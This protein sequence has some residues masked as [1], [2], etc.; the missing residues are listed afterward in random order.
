MK[1]RSWVSRLL[2]S[3]G[4]R[5]LDR[6]LDEEIAAHLEAIEQDA[7]AAGLSA[8]AARRAA[9]R[10]FG[11]IERMKEEHRDMR[12]SRHLESVLQDL[13]FSFRSIHRSAGHSALIAATLALGVAGSSAILS[14][15][16]RLFVRPLPFPEAQRL[17]H[18]DE[19][20][21]DGQESIRVAY[22][23]FLEWQ[24]SAQSFESM[25]VW[26]EEGYNLTAGEA[27]E[28]IEG[29]RVSPGLLNVLGM[30]PALGRTFTAA[31]DQENGPNVVLLSH[32]L[33]QR[34]FD[35]RLDVLG[36]EIELDGV[37]HE[38]VGVLPPEAAYPDHCD[39]W[40]PLQ[41]DPEYGVGWFLIGIARLRDGSSLDAAR[42]ELTRLH[43]SLTE[44]RGANFVTTPV[45]TDFRSHYLGD[46][47][48][49]ASLLLAGVG[50]ALLIAAGNAAGL[51]LIGGL[52]RRNE[53]LTRL[54]LG[55]SRARIVRQ[56]TTES[57]LVALTGAAL[58]ALLG[59]QALAAL[60]RFR[61]AEL[62]AWL[63]FDLDGRFLFTAVVVSLF[64]GLIAGSAAALGATR[65]G[66]S[67]GMARGSASK[68]DR[69]NLDALVV[70]QAGL[71]LALLMTV[72]LLVQALDT[73][74]AVDPGF[75]SE[76]VLTFTM[77]LPGWLYPQPRQRAEFFQELVERLEAL[78][79]VSAAGAISLA[80]LENYSA[81]NFVVEGAGARDSKEPEPPVLTQ[82]AVP[83]YFEA[84]GI[85]LIAGRWFDERE[86]QFDAAPVVIVN[87]TFVR[88]HFPDSS[89]LG[90]RVRYSYR[91]DEWMTVVGVAAD[92]RHFGLEREPPLG[93]YIPLS[94]GQSY[95]AMTMTLK[96]R[97][98]PL[99]LMPDIQRIASEMDPTVPV[100]GVMSLTERLDRTLFMRRAYSW[101]T[102]AFALLSLLLTAVG[103]YGVTAYLVSQRTREIGIRA[104][105]GEQRLTL[106]SKIVRHALALTT[107]GV[108]LGAAAGTYASTW[109]GSLLFGLDQ[110]PMLPLI[111]AVGVL[112][113]TA[114]LASYLP[115]RKV[116]R[117]NPAE[118][119]RME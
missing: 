102:F 104:A 57:L 88:R 86:E 41:A 101:L 16:D 111:I 26:T 69:R 1:L 22:A 62:P 82:A 75:R 109:M 17:V 25:A 97:T 28:R 47:R 45:L 117:L 91:P 103:I 8:E 11:S 83:G 105:L 7:M 50:V 23:N 119:L 2:G 96:T 72:G 15:Y 108:L 70:G 37:A 107:L 85:G 74:Y 4:R 38:I 3:L 61:P 46:Y 92:V 76:N 19:R 43:E 35:S 95:T 112:F 5:R 32:A 59:W 31:E 100:H 80:P 53:L 30:Q 10:Q 63:V 56:F 42:D 116:V 77:S 68:R 34:R 51:W 52:R 94:Q 110:W 29:A 73:V 106:Q 60:L 39:I 6:E 81:T 66:T 114:L 33:W 93:V 87:R 14:V 36:E 115:A 13:R 20:I 113:T 40:T 48:L 89:P 58:G 118:M 71:A 54:A 21:P 78:P 67:N 55:A 18:L 27:A 12:G 98:P 90:R 49:G 65:A 79:Q 84:M 44:S 99:T 9:L 24:E 64:I